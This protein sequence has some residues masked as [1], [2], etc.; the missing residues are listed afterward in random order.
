MMLILP[1]FDGRG[2]GICLPTNILQNYL[3]AMVG[4]EHALQKRRKVRLENNQL[5]H[6]INSHTVVTYHLQDAFSRA[7]VDHESPNPHQSL[8]QQ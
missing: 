6:L 8:C 7:L 3:L 4:P 2:K 1:L 5:P